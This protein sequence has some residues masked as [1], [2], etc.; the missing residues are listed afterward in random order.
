MIELEAIRR[1]ARMK[2]LTNLGFAEKD[3]F[4]EIIL[5]GVSREAPGL[6]FKGGTALSK[7]FGLDRFSEDVDFSG[8]VG[9][10]ELDRICAYLKDFGYGAEYS[11]AKAARGRLLT[12]IVKGFLYKGT[13]QSLARV[14]M[15]VNPESEVVL[16][17]EFR[18]LYPLYPDIPPFGLRVMAAEEMAAEKA[19]ALLVRAKAW[20]AYDLW[21]LVNRGVKVGSGLIDKKLELYG[22]KRTKTALDRALGQCRKNWKRELL[23]M[24][25]GAPDFDVVDKAVR[26][27]LRSGKDR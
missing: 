13:P 20:D 9:K 24:A 22:V 18:M 3:Y 26:K 10:R 23:P 19:R 15:D 1:V 2:G 27:L 14:R 5:L 25:P 16:E 7:F 11:E 12:F 21:F 8:Q 6:V 17:P 4:Q